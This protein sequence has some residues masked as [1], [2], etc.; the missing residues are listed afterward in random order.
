MKATSSDYLVALGAT[1]LGALA[2]IVISAV[3]PFSSTERARFLAGSAF[4]LLFQFFAACTLFVSR[5]RAVQDESAR[6]SRRYKALIESESFQVAHAKLIEI[7]HA[8]ER[9]Q[10]SRITQG[11]PPL[12]ERM[13]ILRTEIDELISSIEKHPNRVLLAAASSQYEL[14]HS[15]RSAMNELLGLAEVGRDGIARAAILL[16]ELSLLGDD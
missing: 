14:L 16:A 4:T 1:A 9:E 6:F 13:Q 12:K 15:S 3:M 7:F 2:M 10:Y 5:D 8:P 11:W